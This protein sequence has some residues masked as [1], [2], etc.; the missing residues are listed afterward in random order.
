MR[1]GLVFKYLIGD[2][3]YEYLRLSIVKFMILGIVIRYDQNQLYV[4]FKEILKK[5]I[6]IYSGKSLD[7]ES[8]LKKKFS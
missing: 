3:F 4:I 5:K 7:L 8:F 1:K 6:M 2:F